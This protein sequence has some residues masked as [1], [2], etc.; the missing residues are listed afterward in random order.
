[1][2]NNEKPAASTTDAVKKETGKKLSFGKRV[3][4]WFR[5]M[6]SELKKIVW[7]TKKQTVNMSVVAV[8]VMLVAAILIWGFDQIAQFIVQAVINLVG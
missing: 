2:S 4:K 5:E 3:A 7:P 8:V 1:M 6:I